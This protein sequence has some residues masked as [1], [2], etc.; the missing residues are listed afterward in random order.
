MASSADKRLLYVNSRMYAEGRSGIRYY[1]QSLYADL[2]AFPSVDEV[3][4]LQT[5]PDPLLGRTRGVV[6]RGLVRAVLFDLLLVLRH[7]R[8]EHGVKVVHGPANILPWVKPRGYGYVV[9]IHDLS[10]LVHKIDAPFFHA[11]YKRA[12][13]RSLKVADRVIA[14]SENTRRDV[15]RF[16]GIPE[17][18]IEVVYSGVNPNFVGQWKRERVIDGRY[19]LSVSTHPKR[20][21]IPRVLE[22]MA[23][24]EELREL[25]YVLAGVIDA[26]QSHELRSIAERLGI[27]DR[28]RLYGYATEEQLISLYQ[29][30]E[31]TIYPSLYEGFGFPVVEAMACACPVITSTTSSLPEVTPDATWLVDPLDV[32][33]ISSAMSRLVALS[34]PERAALVERN[35]EFVTRFDWSGA[36]RAVDAIVRDVAET[37]E[38][39]T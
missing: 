29:H 2:R 32:A 12:V 28:L 13:R 10:F 16:Y 17:E 19:F 18:K 35:A 22:A 39:S 7:T 34:A 1:I 5:G 14:V 37:L 23:S 27:A 31:F 4:F 26:A 8:R 36:R 38:R 24:N 9:T 15:M 20:K 30:A 11:Y 6:Q 25:T 21:N 33:D 3:V